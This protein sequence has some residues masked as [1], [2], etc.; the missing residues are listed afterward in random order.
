MIE[1]EEIELMRRVMKDPMN[2][3]NER[4]WVGVETTLA[5]SATGDA[6]IQ[7]L[8]Q[9]VMVKEEAKKEMVDEPPLVA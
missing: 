6:A 9:A 7:E 2:R 4:Q 3:H 5:F 1:K 8:K